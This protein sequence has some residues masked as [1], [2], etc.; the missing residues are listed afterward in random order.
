MADLNARLLQNH[1]NNDCL[2][3]FSNRDMGAVGYWYLLNFWADR[4]DYCSE[5]IPSVWV[6]AQ[7]F[8]YRLYRVC[9]SAS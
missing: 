7:G 1:L 5:F 2:S 8:R 9:Y 6:K 4:Q 3:L